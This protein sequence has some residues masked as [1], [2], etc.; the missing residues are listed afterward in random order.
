MTYR[1]YNRRDAGGR[2]YQYY[3][4]IGGNSSKVNGK[5]VLRPQS[6]SHLNL[7]VSSE[8]RTV[9]P[10]GGYT[11]SDCF[12]SGFDPNVDWS[13]VDNIVLSKMS[14]KLK[15]EKANLGLTAYTW[16]QSTEMITR[17][18][19]EVT[20]LFKKSERKLRSDPK[21]KRRAQKW[22]K[23]TTSANTILEVE[24]GWKSLVEDLKAAYKVLG[25]D[26]P[27]GNFV[28]RHRTPLRSERRMDTPY[29][30][31]N[32]DRWSEFD[33]IAKCS[34]AMRAE[35]TNHNLWL[36]NQLGLI[37]LP[38]IAWDAVPWSFLVNMFGN[39][40]QIINSVTDRVGL[41]VTNENVTRTVRGKY[42]E[43]LSY[44][45]YVSDTG[46]YASEKTRDFVYVN[47]TTKFRTLGT[48]PAMTLQYKLPNLN[49]ELCFIAG[50]LMVQQIARVTRLISRL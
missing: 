13:K 38:G 10:S 33:G 49:L 17:R 16:R 9:Y 1:F 30:P 41:N 23:E 29:P 21:F 42:H 40:N 12:M 47:Y 48:R 45:R 2:W 26:I 25:T 43:M 18:F 19:G 27:D 31:E 15:T 4:M 7:E 8:R 28:A 35:V 50:G 46:L 24:F 44:N 22:D 32:R 20:N 39:F 37:N 36:A 3:Q 6:L 5:L 11:V 14:N 34:Y